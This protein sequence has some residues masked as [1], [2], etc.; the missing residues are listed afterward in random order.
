MKFERRSLAQKLRQKIP[1][2]QC[3]EGLNHH[4]IRSGKHIFGCQDICRQH[5]NGALGVGARCLED[6]RAL[7]LRQVQVKQDQARLWFALDAFQTGLPIHA[8]I[9]SNGRPNQAEQDFVQTDQ[10][11]VILDNQYQWRIAHD[12]LPMGRQTLKV[13]PCPASLWTLISP[14]ISSTNCF[15][16]DRP[17]PAPWRDRVA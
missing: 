13:E 3:I 17:S 16:I 14:P 4:M 9:G 11:G 2:R 5:H 6:L 7:D 8:D 12:G 15:E 1:E 10:V